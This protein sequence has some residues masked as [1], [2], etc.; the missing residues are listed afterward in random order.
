MAFEFTTITLPD[1]REVP[2]LS[3]S[4]DHPWAEAAYPNFYVEGEGFELAGVGGKG[5][6][7]HCEG[8]R[9]VIAAAAANPVL[10]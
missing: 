10:A 8:D 2:V 7:F 6:Y 5:N 9:Q 4:D 3:V 1:D